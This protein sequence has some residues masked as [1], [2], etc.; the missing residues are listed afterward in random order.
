MTIIKNKACFTFID[1]FAGIGGFRLALEKYDGHCVFSS[2]WDVHSQKTYAANFGEIPYGDITKIQ[3][4][5]IPP[6]DVLCAGFPCQS[7]SISGKR[8]G[9]ND[10]RGTLFRDIVR[11]AKYHKPKILFLENV[12]NI[13]KHDNENT[14]TVIKNTLIKLGYTLFIKM[15]RSSDFGVPQARERVYFIAFRNDLGVTGFDFPTQSVEVKVVKD[16]L[17]PE[18]VKESVYIIRNDIF[19]KKQN[20]QVID[21]RRPLQIGII[22][23]GGQ[24]ERIY[25]IDAAGITLSAYGG[26]AASKTGA[27][28]INGKIR[29]LIPRECARMQGFPETFIIPVADNVA[30]KQF[31]DS[32][33]VPVLES[34]FSNILKTYQKLKVEIKYTQIEKVMKV[35]QQLEF[36]TLYA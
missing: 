21:K 9:F 19:I 20:A 26:G 17:E 28:L 36:N 27:Y 30:Y 29:K 16:I 2:E 7:F 5:E 25:S 13:L 10:T 4:T 8:Q 24:G 12:K 3:E 1:L 35:N 18:P 22:N 31:G 33:S 15:L 6:H 11:I 23:K 32:V 34:L 14:I